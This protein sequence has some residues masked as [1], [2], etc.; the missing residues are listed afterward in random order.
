MRCMVLL[1]TAAL[2][3]APAS[4]VA[5]EPP[6]QGQVSF[7]NS[8]APAAQA[9][10]H[11]GLA[12]LHNFQYAHAATAF[13]EA[14]AADPG[15][16]MAYWGE[17]MSHNH[18]VWMEQDAKQG[19]AALAKLG[20]TPA[21][22]LAKAKTSRERAFLGAVEALYGE[23][24]K[25]QR[26]FAYSARMEQVYR[27]YPQDVDAASLYALS[28]LGLAHKGRDYGLYMR[29]AGVLE[30]FFPTY[31]R[32]PGVVHYLIHSYDDPTHAPLGLRAARLYG[33]IAP[34]SDHAQ[35]MTSH[36]YIALADWPAT[37]DANLKAMELVNRNRSAAG[38]GAA[39]CGHYNE[40][41]HYSYL[42]L[43]RKDEAAALLS[44]CRT[45]AS[46]EVANAQSTN[47]WGLMRSY[48][49]MRA[50]AIVDSGDGGPP[51][52]VDAA[53]FPAEEFDLAYGDLLL[54]RGKPKD[55]VVAYDRLKASGAKTPL[56]EMHP[57]MGKRL[58][59]VLLQA[60]GLASIS[61]GHDDRGIAKL[62]E[63]AEMERAMEVPFGPPLVEKPSFELLAEELAALGRNAEAAE[64]YAA[65]L[66]LAP[67]RKRSLAGLAAMQKGQPGS[68]STAAAAP[69]KH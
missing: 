29:S 39:N 3:L 66:K 55:V 4:L 35:H 48:G 27:A 6:S 62:R 38:R 34:G 16:A 53:R 1:A 32:H 51:I 52:A 7:A 46:A 11:R 5:Q 37:I 54:A 10:F 68:V 49:S 59:I 40:W 9:A 42:Q 44:E 69:H 33:D 41:L 8:G 22:R 47:R 13:Q 57:Q 2:C 45:A 30:Q 25:E 64:A 12:Q 61:S 43:G 15:F 31:Q 63:A 21:A 23:G 58:Q 36:I 28:L 18:T 56:A 67:G 19:R 17:A 50:Q 60:E 24:T 14:Q 26:D 20:A 65:A